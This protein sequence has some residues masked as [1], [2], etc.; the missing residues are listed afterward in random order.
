MGWQTF[1]MLTYLAGFV[2]T[3]LVWIALRLIEAALLIAPTTTT[4]R[5][6]STDVGDALLVAVIWPLTVPFAMWRAVRG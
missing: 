3:M 2:L 4:N 1:L 5:F 6:E